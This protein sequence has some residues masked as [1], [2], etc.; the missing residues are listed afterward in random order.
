VREEFL[1]WEEGTSFKYRGTGAPLME[2]AT[3]RWSLEPMG[4]KTLVTS[5]AELKVRGG[6][7]GRLLEP[8]LYLAIRFGLPNSLAPLKYYVET[9]KPFWGDPRR[10]PVAQATC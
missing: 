2:W 10:L 3:N 5:E 9:G 4:D 6:I 8:V 7:F 1:E